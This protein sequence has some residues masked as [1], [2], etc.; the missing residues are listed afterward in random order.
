MWY[1]IEEIATY[2]VLQDHTLL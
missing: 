2:M 1:R